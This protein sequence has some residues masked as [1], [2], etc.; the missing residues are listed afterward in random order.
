MQNP[1][2]SIIVPAYNAENSI[3]KCVDSI[4]Q[5]SLFDIEIIVVDD[6]S[7]DETPRILTDLDKQHKRLRVI[8]NEENKSACYSRRVGIH[9]SNGKYIM[10]VD[11]D[12]ALEKFACETAYNAIETKQVD[13]LQFGVAVK[14]VKATPGQIE[15][16]EDFLTYK[17][18]DRITG[19]LL[20]HCFESKVFGFTIWNK[21]YNA[22]L[23]K[24]AA[25]NLPTQP[26]YKAQDLLLQF[27][28]LLYA[29]SIDSIGDSLYI[30]SYGTGVTGGRKFT[31][32]KIAIHMAQAAIV[33]II[34]DFLLSRGLLSLHEEVVRLIAY[35]LI[36]DNLATV[37]FCMG[38]ALES[39]AKALFL[40]HWG[41]G[42]SCTGDA[43]SDS[44]SL[45]LK[46]VYHLSESNPLFDK[47]HQQGVLDDYQRGVHE[48]VKRI[49]QTL[50]NDPEPFIPIVMASN[51]AYIP[52]LAVAIESIKSTT[53]TKIYLFIFYTDLE[54]ETIQRVR[55]LSTTNLHIELIDVSPFID[56]DT[57]Y[58]RAHY[59]IE[60]YYRLIIAEVFS[61][62][63]KVI[64]LDCDIVVM[65]DL[66]ELYQVDLGE[67]ILAAAKNPV[68][69]FMASYL[70]D[71]LRFSRKEYFN[72]GVIIINTEAFIRNNTKQKCLSFL[73]INDSLAC[74]DQDTLNV[75]C[76]GQVTFIDQRWNFQWHHGLVSRQEKNFADLLEDEK[77]DYYSSGNNIRILHYT[78]NI[79][80]WNEPSE[81]LANYF[82]TYAKQSPFLIDILNANIKRV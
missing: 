2:V 18:K 67:N 70:E 66:H 32:S 17:S 41:D 76:Q 25:S 75:V 28:I 36:S 7:T 74:P 24:V 22:R 30:Y 47:L 53:K 20:R 6:C 54:V 31:L 58:T 10:F 13:I 59:S 45:F 73:S 12:D 63:A 56:I 46:P 23:V 60:M 35:D 80:P 77:E 3:G 55:S 81:K 69:K 61:Y 37:T 1:K 48:Q 8:T 15:W 26:I 64:Y 5:Q 51:E 34:Y 29:V 27:F 49:E 65:S 78:S 16:F 38:T 72:S 9:A 39:H 4:I 62:L 42:S 82:W 57:L 43:F 71:R 68:H 40:R 79:K 14:A 44:L 21:I 33:R 19:N 50:L 11:A 52:Y